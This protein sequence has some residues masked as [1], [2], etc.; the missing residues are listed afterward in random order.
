VTCCC[1][2]ALCGALN[3]KP[4]WALGIGNRELGIGNRAGP[5]CARG[6][7]RWRTRLKGNRMTEAG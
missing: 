4:L 2:C 1:C 7:C 3:P 6:A 5:L